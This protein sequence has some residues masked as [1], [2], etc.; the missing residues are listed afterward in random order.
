MARLLDL[1][2]PPNL[3]MVALSQRHSPQHLLVA[4][5]CHRLDEDQTLPSNVRQLVLHR[6]C[7]PRAAILGRGDIRKLYL[8]PQYQ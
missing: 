1:L 3:R 8:F 2:Q 7:H 4:T 6:Y 5:Q